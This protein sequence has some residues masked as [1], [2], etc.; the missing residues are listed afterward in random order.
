MRLFGNLRNQTINF[1]NS[2]TIKNALLSNRHR[3]LL[4]CYKKLAWTAIVDVKLST[5]IFFI[6]REY[7]GCS[8]LHKKISD[9]RQHVFIN[10]TFYLNLKISLL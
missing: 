6:L 3:L 7:D 2:S 1:K 8:K 5:I 4:L 9:Q 10:S